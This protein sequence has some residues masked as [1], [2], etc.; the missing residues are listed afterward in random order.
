MIQ[1]KY[2]FTI[3]M[4]DWKRFIDCEIPPHN[5]ESQKELHI[6]LLELYGVKSYIDKM[7]TDTQWHLSS[8]PKDEKNM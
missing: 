4:E 6:Q 1:A 3:S 8:L 5:L 2:I 7:I